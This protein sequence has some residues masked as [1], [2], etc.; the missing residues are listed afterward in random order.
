MT[1][2]TSVRLALEGGLWLGRQPMNDGSCWGDPPIE[3]GQIRSTLLQLGKVTPESAVFTTSGEWIGND[4]PS[5]PEDKRTFTFHA[6]DNRLW[7]LDHS[8]RLSIPSS[9]YG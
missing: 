4:V 1:A 7:W 3:K 2:L 5:P 6:A 9:R 8:S